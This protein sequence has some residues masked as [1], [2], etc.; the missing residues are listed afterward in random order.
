MPGPPPAGLARGLGQGPAVA[1]AVPVAVGAG[2]PAVGAGAPVVGAT[3]GPGDVVTVDDGVG[4]PVGKG[5]GA[6]KR[7]P[8]WAGV[9][10]GL[11]VGFFVGTGVVRRS[12]LVVVV[13]AGAEVRAGAAAVGGSGSIR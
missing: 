6:G 3:P 9:A 5:V 12:G 7:G 11:E 1:G 10:S 4:V 8:V 2:M 13:G